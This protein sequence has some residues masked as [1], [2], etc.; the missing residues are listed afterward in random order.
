M[1]KV[2]KLF[3]CPSHRGTRRGYV[4]RTEAELAQQEKVGG[5]KAA[6]LSEDEMADYFRRSNARVI[7]DLSFTKFLPIEE[8]RAHHDYASTSS[9]STP[10][11][12]S[13]TGCSSI[14]DAR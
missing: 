3:A 2:T 13:G 10:T 14:R 6:F 7:L 4:F 8:I 5:T 1:G 12:Y 9:A 11:S